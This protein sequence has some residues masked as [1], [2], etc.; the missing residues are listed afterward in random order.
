MKDVIKPLGAPAVAN[1]NTSIAVQRHNGFTVKGER[2]KES[3][4]DWSNAAGK[5]EIYSSTV[6]SM[7]FVQALREVDRVQGAV[8]CPAP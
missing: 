4:N 5:C 1:I 3:R 7:S 2:N 6:D 8:K